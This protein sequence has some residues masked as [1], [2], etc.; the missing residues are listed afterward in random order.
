MLRSFRV[1]N[2]KSI[3]TEQELLLIPSYQG[4]MPVLPVAAVFGANASGKSNLLDALRWMQRAVQ[5]SYRSWEADSGIPRV[6]YRLQLDAAAKPSDFVVDLLI[7]GIQ[8]VYGVSVTGDAVEEEWLHTY[9]RGR[10]RVIFERRRQHVELGSTVPERRS[11]AE[12]LSSLLRDNAL[13]LS[14]AVQAKQEEVLPVYRWFREDLRI[15][16][17][18]RSW[19]GGRRIAAERVLAAV[20]QHPEFMELLRV[21]DLGISDLQIVER[22]EVPSAV[23]F[24]RADRIEAEIAQT[25]GT[26]F[27]D[28]PGSESPRLASLRR[29]LDY[30]RSPKTRRE[31]LF[32]H[33]ADR[34]A[35]GTEEESDGTLAWVELLLAAL[36]ALENG[37]L[38]VTDE[39]DA[40]LHPRLTARLVE[41]FRSTATNTRGAQLL[42]TTHDAT[43][44]GTNLGDEVLKRDEIWFIEKENGASRLYPLSD[45][46]PRKGENRERRYLAGSYGAVPAIFEDSLVDAVLA[47]REE[48][49]DAPA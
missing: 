42:F 30:L 25:G 4:A 19:S 8:F 35:L 24:T 12:V 11:R 45:F 15:L 44:L 7:D 37:A 27:G 5:N 16:G 39:I 21:A 10:E 23:D 32:L 46:H 34:V 38:L 31:V 1:S 20:K 29:E 22:T 3:N 47:N 41:L 36:S 17:W 6:P 33:G 49:C 28:E 26:S 43:L 13:L 14:T 48:S 18:R 2:H 9:P 40:S